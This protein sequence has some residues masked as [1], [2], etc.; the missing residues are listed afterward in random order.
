MWPFFRFFALFIFRFN[1]PRHFP[2]NYYWLFFLSEICFESFGC[3]LAVEKGKETAHWKKRNERGVKVV[4]ILPLTL[5][6]MFQRDVVD[7]KS[8]DGP[9]SKQTRHLLWHSSAR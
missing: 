3:R 4:F 7:H 1:K 6:F 2:L 5:S 9:I 8:G